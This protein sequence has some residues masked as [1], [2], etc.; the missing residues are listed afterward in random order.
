MTGC[1][2]QRIDSPVIFLEPYPFDIGTF[3][4]F[5][6]GQ[7]FFCLIAG[8]IGIVLKRFFLVDGHIAL[9]DLILAALCRLIFQFFPNRFLIQPQHIHQGFDCRFHIL[10]F[11]IDHFTVQDHFIHFLTGRQYHTIPV[12]DVPTFERDHTA[13]ILLL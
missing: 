8:H 5:F 1:G 7:C 4:D 2:I 10:F 12:G 11:G 6:F 3:C 13:V 9:Q